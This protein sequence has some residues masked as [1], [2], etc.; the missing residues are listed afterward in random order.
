MTSVTQRRHPPYPG[1]PDS[2][3]SVS[4]HVG[5]GVRI[6]SEQVSGFDRNTHHSGVGRIESIRVC[7]E[8]TCRWHGRFWF[9][10]HLLVRSCQYAQVF[11]FRSDKGPATSTS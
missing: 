2:P 4:G 6:E 10:L 3:E 7:E 9:G 11:R 1:C 8:P 5:M